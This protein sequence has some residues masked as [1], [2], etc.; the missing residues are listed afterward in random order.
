MSP[1]SAERGTGLRTRLGAVNTEAFRLHN[2]G[3][4]YALILLLITL[5]I[6]TK[7]TGR[8]AYLSAI[9][10]ANVFDQTTQVGILAVFMTIV[11]ISGNFD[12]SIGATA[13]LAAG[14]T[15]IVLNH[16]DVWVAIAA[17]LTVGT[18]VGIVNGILVQIV[19]INAFIV[20]LGALTAVR[21][22]LLIATNG[23]SIVTGKTSLNSLVDGPAP[24][25]L[26]FASVVV[27]L[28]VVLVGMYMIKRAHDLGRPFDLGALGAVIAGG[29]LAVVGVL[30][31]PS[32]W[33]LTKQ[34]WV[35]FAV[36]LVSWFVLSYTAVGRRLYA[37]G[38]NTEAARLSGIDINRYKIA[39]FV[40]NGFAAAVVGILYAGRFEAINPNALSG[41]ELT[42]LAA[43]IL[44]GTSL[45]GGSGSVVKTVVGALILFVLANGFNILNLG[46]NYQPL[47]QGLVII[48]AA[49]IYVVAGR[50]AS[51]QRIRSAG[52]EVSSSPD[53]IERPIVGEVTR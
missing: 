16:A 22:I 35:L 38:G 9:N 42:V 18:L 26:K 47:I 23:E 29:V 10:T 5:V 49:A 46:A 3:V 51:S 15:L 52:A 30:A 36:T 6:S 19:G 48:G 12:L 37:V 2:A 34:V 39:P 33:P 24:L 14:L 45:F 25:N 4:V 11:L 32:D 7:V 31:F 28:V 20:T 17:G 44:G 13:A 53:E 40:L 27:G 41:I 8:P 50:R 21:G 1:A 43:A